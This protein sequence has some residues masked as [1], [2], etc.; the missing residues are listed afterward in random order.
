MN[1]VYVLFSLLIVILWSSCRKDFTTVTNSGHLEFSLDTVYF[2]TLFSKIPSNTVE[3]KIYNRSDDD[4]NIPEIYLE[5][6]VSSKYSLNVNGFPGPN[7]TPTET[8][9][10][11]FSNV[12]I[13]ANDSIFVFAQVLVDLE[14]DTVDD[15]GFYND[16][17]YFS[18]LDQSQSIDLVSFVYDATIIYPTEDDEERTFETS[19]IDE[20]GETIT[21]T[22]YNLETSELFWTN[23]KPIVV[24]GK[25]VVPTGETL[26]VDAGTRI[27]FHEDSGLIVESGASI[28]F[29]GST[30][31]DQDLL[32]NEI[33]IESD[34]IAE[35]YNNLPGQWGYIWIMAG[36]VNNYITNTTIKNST[37]GILI[38]GNGTET[39]PSLNL[40]NVQIYNSAA[41]GIQANATNIEANNIVINNCGLASLNIEQGGTYNF[42]YC[43]LVNYY[44][45]GVRS[46]RAVNLSNQEQFNSDVSNTD[47][48]ANFVNCI[49][50]GSYDTEITFNNNASAEFTF[51]F[52]NCLIDCSQ[53][54]SGTNENF[55]LTNSDL[56]TNCIFN[57]NPNFENT[58]NNQLRISETSAAN[59]KAKVTGI[60]ND[61]TGTE[62]NSLNPDIGAYE[63]TTFE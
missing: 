53:N 19:Y 24:Y 27:H 34:R 23:D 41:A 9:G 49:I 3:F 36:S 20:T 44:S 35:D 32:E 11:E 58:G 61:I 40:E 8:L 54:L 47:L 10:K 50:T 26:I 5:K 25:A 14:E 45:F 17:I 52:E 6:G 38:E 42:E 59:G 43:S 28:N 62:R 18:G 57:E 31:A 1:K 33:I 12:S 55:D 15:E 21:E 46:L 56:Y 48:E 29:N 22:G 51:N 16:K 39:S 7:E 2:D 63:S 60:S 30:S 4:I 37:T 13:L